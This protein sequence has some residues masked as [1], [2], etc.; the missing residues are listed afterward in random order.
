MIYIYLY[1]DIYI[2]YYIMIYIYIIYYA[3]ICFCI[4]WILW[5]DICAASN[6]VGNVAKLSCVSALAVDCF[7]GIERQGCQA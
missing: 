6:G 7:Q 1:Y 2:Y 4:E 5:S 3:H